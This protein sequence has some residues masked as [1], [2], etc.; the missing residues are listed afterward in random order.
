MCSFCC[1]CSV[2]LSCLTL[3]NPKDCST[4]GFPALHRL[5]EFVQT[6]VHWGGDATQP[7]HP[8]LSPS[9]PASI[10]PS[11]RV[12]SN[13]SALCIRRSEYW[14][15]SISPPSEYSGLISFRI[16]RF[17]LLACCPGNSHK[18]SPATQFKPSCPNLYFSQ[19]QTV[20]VKPRE[21]HH[22]VM[23]ISDFPFPQSPIIFWSSNIF[24]D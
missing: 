2:T 20:R 22:L 13:E 4:L 7:S 14:S 23:R 1:C 17:D 6:H 24:Q 19:T 15:F 10:L 3:C 5:P 16:D 18:F 9:L 21:S 12:F 8:L 11:I